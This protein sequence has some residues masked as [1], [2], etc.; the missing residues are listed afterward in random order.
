M[1]NILNLQT[2]TL[3]LPQEGK[4]SNKSWTLCGSSSNYS[5]VFC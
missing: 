1:A 3:E 5:P 4:E 2:E